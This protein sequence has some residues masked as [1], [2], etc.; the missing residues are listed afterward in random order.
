MKSS[1]QVIKKRRAALTDYLK[2]KQ[3]AT[4]NELSQQF[5]VS[6]MTIR[7]DCE[8]LAK[9]GL[10]E[11]SFGK[12]VYV[13]QAVD[14]I[15]SEDPLDKLKDKLAKEASDLIS[16]GQIIFINS[17]NTAVKVL[18]YLTDK[19][20]TVLTNN[21]HALDYQKNSKTNVVLSGGEVNFAKEVMIGDIAFNSFNS[22][23]SNVTLIGCNG[24]NDQ[25]G[26]STSQ[27]NEARINRKI[28]QNSGQVVVLAD[29]TKLGKVSNF[30]VGSI[31]DV[32]VLITDS[33]ADPKLVAKF[34]KN[35]IQVIQVPI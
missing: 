12:V 28:I 18:E 21:L 2:E 7:R 15:G 17:S 20:I 4:V 11:R 24:L 19:N 5:N 27:I 30:T 16:D 32:D 9:M 22:M 13:E 1:N 33:F 10:L 3:T 23:R 35:G 26:I 25:T 6:E 34:E 31:D 14:K 29:Y 8:I